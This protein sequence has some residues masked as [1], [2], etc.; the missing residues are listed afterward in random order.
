[1]R[2]QFSELPMHELIDPNSMM[3]MLDA[4]EAV[5]DENVEQEGRQ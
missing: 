4:F 2:E 3:P 1:M 5:A